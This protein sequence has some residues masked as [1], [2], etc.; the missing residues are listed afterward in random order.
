MALMLKKLV[1]DPTV[2]L[3]VP[4][5]NSTNELLDLCMAQYKEAYGETPAKGE[6]VNALLRGA[7]ESDKL[8]MKAAGKA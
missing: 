7:L 2:R 5:L 3:N 4:I 6:I 8:L 1:K